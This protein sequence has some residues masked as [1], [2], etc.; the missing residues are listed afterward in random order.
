MIGVNR[1]LCD[2]TALLGT[3]Y[4]WYPYSI[5]VVASFMSLAIPV[6]LLGLTSGALGRDW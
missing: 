3:N 6:A 5:H 2:Y 4:L 1:E